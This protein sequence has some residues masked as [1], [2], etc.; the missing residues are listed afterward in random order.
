MEWQTCNRGVRNHKPAGDQPTSQR[1]ADIRRI[2]RVTG[3][4]QQIKS[5]AFGR[6][7]DDRFRYVQV[8]ANYLK[9]SNIQDNSKH[10]GDS[11]LNRRQIRAKGILNPIYGAVENIVKQNVYRGAIVSVINAV[12]D[13]FTESQ[14]FAQCIIGCLIKAL[15]FTGRMTKFVKRRAE[16]AVINEAKFYFPSTMAGKENEDEKA[17]SPLPKRSPASSPSFKQGGE[18][19]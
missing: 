7:K 11:F 14:W 15:T 5:K 12:P 17:L 9:A 2:W 10:Y 19:K 8:W 16:M 13:R 18:K 4:Q 1:S 6:S 3:W